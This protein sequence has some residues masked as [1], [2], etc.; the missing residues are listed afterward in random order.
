MS[1]SLHS[2]D[3]RAFVEPLVERRR[4]QGM[5]QVDLAVALGK[6]QS[7]VSKYER[8]ERRLDPA[9]YRMILLALGLDPA[10]AF[11]AVHAAL[12]DNRRS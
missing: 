12:D 9:E 11:K 8:H 4:A 6:P 10:K 7:F 2:T 1:L 3:Y 5:T